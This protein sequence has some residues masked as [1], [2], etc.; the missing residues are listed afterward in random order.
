MIARVVSSTLRQPVTRRNWRDTE[1]RHEY[2]RLKREIARQEAEIR[3][4]ELGEEFE[5]PYEITRDEFVV[6]SRK[7]VARMKHRLDQMWWSTA[8]NSVVN[9]FR[10][11]LP[12]TALR[13]NDRWDMLTGVCDPWA[14]NP[15]Q[16][17]RDGS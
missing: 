3:R 5:D 14:T 17:I 13:R 12:S 7:E 2:L 11:L 9:G 10:Q 15:P 4:A 8:F 6:S 1:W 16:T